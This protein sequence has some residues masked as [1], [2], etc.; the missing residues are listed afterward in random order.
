MAKSQHNTSLIKICY[1]IGPLISWWLPTG[2]MAGL[3][4]T[5]ERVR[6]SIVAVGTVMPTR[7]PKALFRGTGFVVGNGRY[8]ITNHHVLP[9]DMNY[10]RMET[11]AIFTGKGKNAKG[12]AAKVL[13]K[14]ATH[15]LALLEIKGKPLPA[16][17]IGDES[18]VRE[19][20][21]YAFTGFPIGMVLGLHPVTHRGIVS[22]ITPIVIPSLNSKQ[23]GVKHIRR[24]R[25]PYNVFQLD[26]TAYPGNSGSPLYE[27][28]SGRVIGVVNSVLVKDTKES[29]LENPTGITYAIPVKYV[30]K[31]MKQKIK[32]D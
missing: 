2:V 3:P 6:A 5:V 19:G 18:S 8:V 20:A 26:A 28:D 1:F 12:R 29:A 25:S 30:K 22:A 32:A 7:S 9:E 15:D 10:E 14:D 4:D 21:L 11:L 27:V 16:L 31:L 13:A 23:L 24:M 17:K